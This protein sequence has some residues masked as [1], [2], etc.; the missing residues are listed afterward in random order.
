MSNNEENRQEADR[1]VLCAWCLEE[2]LEVIVGWA[3]VPNSHGICRKHEKE[4]NRQTEKIAGA[5]AK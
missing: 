2:G 1:E 3:R 4:L 5:E